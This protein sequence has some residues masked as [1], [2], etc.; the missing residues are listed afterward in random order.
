VADLPSLATPAELAAYSQGSISATDPAAQAALDGASAAVRA[1]CGWHIYPAITET[2]ILDGPGGRVLGLPSRHVTAVTAISQA[3][4][5]VAATSYKWSALGDIQRKDWCNWSTD[6]RDIEVTLTHG[7]T[8]VPADIRQAL[9]AIVARGMSSPTGATR[10]QTL[11][12]SITW[13]TTASGVSGGLA[14]LGPEYNVLDAYR[15]VTS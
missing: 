12:S 9:L 4:S 5:S 8:A 2:L 11:T 15:I 10:E 3:A 13:A 14:I 1:Y 6:Y 7:Y